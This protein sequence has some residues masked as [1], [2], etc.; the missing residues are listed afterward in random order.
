MH[1]QD[2]SG[3]RRFGHH[4]QSDRND[5]RSFF[6]QAEDGIRDVEVTG[7]QTCALPILKDWRGMILTPQERSG[8][9]VEALRL[10]RTHSTYEIA[11]LEKSDRQKYWIKESQI[12]VF[13]V[14]E[15]D[16]KSVV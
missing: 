8:F 2:S 9:L 11:L 15:G 4:S 6:F 1:A 10:L 13:V 3:R 14:F 7:V 12:G 5:L 16:R